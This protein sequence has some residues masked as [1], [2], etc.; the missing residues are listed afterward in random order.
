MRRQANEDWKDSNPP[1]RHM[2]CEKRDASLSSISSKSSASP[3]QQAQS[4]SQAHRLLPSTS[5]RS[6]L[7]P[8]VFSSSSSRKPETRESAASP[9]L[10]KHY[11]HPLHLP[12]FLLRPSL[13]VP[14]TAAGVELPTLAGD[15]LSTD[16]IT[17]TSAIHSPATSLQ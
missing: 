12:V 1:L 11:A 13:V 17:R 6:S 10:H 15:G 14:V 9:S 4:R 16:T 7:A 5:A 8:H 3:G 2:S